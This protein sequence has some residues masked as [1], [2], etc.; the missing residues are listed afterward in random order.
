M[1]G[2]GHSA[3]GLLAG[4]ALLPVAPILPTPT[5]Q[6][7]WVVVCGGMAMLNDADHHSST[8]SRMW[9]WPSR[10][11]A[12]GIG[13]VFGGHRNGTHSLLGVA[14]F[15]LAA[16]IADAWLGQWGRMFWIALAIGLALNAITPILPNRFRIPQGVPIVGGQTLYPENMILAA[17]VVISW[18]GAWWMANNT[19]PAVSAWL[20]WAVAVGMLTHMVGDWFTKG[21]V[22]WLW[23]LRWRSAAGLW[24]TG[25]WFEK[26]IVTPAAVAGAVLL[27]DH[28]GVLGV[29]RFVDATSG[30][31]GGLPWQPE[32]VDLAARGAAVA[33]VAGL[34]AYATAK[35]K[36]AWGAL[37]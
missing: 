21:G 4:A 30:V 17:N 18:A 37:T 7:S 5:A 14:V 27:F 35:D 29:D 28:Y 13:K 6:A 34:V 9:G 32:Q 19:P 31:L 20:P 26:A 3:T 22:P 1:M 8:I 10:A 23:P 12:A 24:T 36:R 2:A 16:W 25:S 33:V 11:A 15:V